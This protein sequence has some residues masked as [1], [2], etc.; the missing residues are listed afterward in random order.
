MRRIKP[1]Y[2]VP[3]P[4]INAAFAFAASRK[5]LSGRIGDAVFFSQV[6]SGEAVVSACTRDG[7]VLAKVPH[8]SSPNMPPLSL[9]G[10]GKSFCMKDKW[11]K[12]LKKVRDHYRSVPWVG[13][14]V[15]DK[16]LW[17]LVDESGLSIIPAYGQRREGPG[18]EKA[19]ATAMDWLDAHPATPYFNDLSSPNISGIDMKNMVGAILD[20]Q[21]PAPI[22]S[23]HEAKR[24]A[25]AVEF[26]DIAGSGQTLISHS[27]PWMVLA[28]KGGQGMVIL[29]SSKP[30][31]IT[32]R[33]LQKAT[34]STAEDL[35]QSKKQLDTVRVGLGI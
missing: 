23:C 3:V 25:Q 12:C 6:P 27:G 21:E 20:T 14:R 30:D 9:T 13:G 31:K 5:D 28:D 32:E 8:V 22:V 34:L 7:V 15:W 35:T 18:G 26:L 4:L 24:I 10:E 11:N 1:F 33:D 2:I 16:N 29:S 17:A 19:E